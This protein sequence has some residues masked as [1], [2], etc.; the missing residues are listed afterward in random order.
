VKRITT[1]GEDILSVLTTVRNEV[2]AA[3][4]ERQVPWENHA[5][6]AK[7][8]FSPAAP[9]PAQPQ[10]PLSPDALAWSV[11]Q[12]TT[13]EAVLEEF[14]RRFPDSVY[15]GFA[16]ARVHEMR[17]KQMAI[18]APPKPAQA[19]PAEEACADGLLV[20]VAKGPKPCIKPGSGES[21]K[22]CPECPEMVVVPQ[23][24]FVMGSP[25]SEPEREWQPGW[26]SPRR[27]DREALR[28]GQICGDS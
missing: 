20:A 2:L 10:A 6:R 7:F 15:A 26:E 11:V 19:Q 9:A 18:A 25:D 21:F 16:K 24:S 1:P 5:L 28:S 14:I 23:G 13:S 17:H 22:D 3:T 12:N 27:N 8:Y 4:A